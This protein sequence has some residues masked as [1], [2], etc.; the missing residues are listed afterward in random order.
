MQMMIFRGRRTRLMQRRQ[1]APALVQSGR[2]QIHLFL[3][4][5]K[6]HSGPKTRSSATERSPKKTPHKKQAT[7]IDG[8]IETKGVRIFR[9]TSGV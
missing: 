9:K 1:D 6:P 4:P 3:F 7:P 8:A 5:K 2:R